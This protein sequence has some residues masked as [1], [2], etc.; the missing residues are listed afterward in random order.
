MTV[1][2]ARSALEALQ[3]LH[4]TKAAK[5]WAPGFTLR[6]NGETYD[7]ASSMEMFKQRQV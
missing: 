6:S 7:R 1:E 4:P 2:V 3:S 5:Y